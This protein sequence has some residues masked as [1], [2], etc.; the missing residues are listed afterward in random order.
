MTT[1]RAE[2]TI[3]GDEAK[4]HQSGAGGF[5]V[6]DACACRLMSKM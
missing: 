5:V 2:E 6:D 1:T 3:N 4:V